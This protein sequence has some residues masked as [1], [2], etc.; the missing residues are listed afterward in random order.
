MPFTWTAERERQMLLLAIS[1]A[2]LKPT[3]QTWVIVAGILGEGLTPS[4][5]R[6]D[7]TLWTI[8]QNLSSTFNP[9][10]TRQIAKMS[11]Y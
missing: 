7:H 5:V 4:A 10:L 3:T 11:H 6:F 2:D 8:S 1:E 9:K